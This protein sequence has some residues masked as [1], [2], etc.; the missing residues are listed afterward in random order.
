MQ[1]C[2]AKGRM[3]FLSAMPGEKN[4]AAVLSDSDVADIRLSKRNLSDLALHYGVSKTSIHEARTGSTFS[5]LPGHHPVVPK[6]KITQAEREEIANSQEPTG[7]LVRR[8]LVSY[9]T[10]CRLRKRRKNISGMSAAV[11]IKRTT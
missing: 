6:R 2:I 11:G 10:I 9:S 4:P 3:V 5:H 8:M 7:A 1:D